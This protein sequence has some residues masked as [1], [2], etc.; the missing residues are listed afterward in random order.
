MPSAEMPH[1]APNSSPVC[2]PFEPDDLD[3]VPIDVGAGSGH[4]YWSNLVA[5]QF[6]DPRMCELISA[7]LR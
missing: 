7:N 2:W 4:I 6:D 3:G 1:M 5:V